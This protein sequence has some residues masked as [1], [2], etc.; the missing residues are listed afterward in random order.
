MAERANPFPGLR[1]FQPGDT[2]V[3]FGREAQTSELLTRLRSNRFVAVVGASGGGKS[4]L[5]LAGL[6]PS[7]H[8]GLM[9]R[10]GSS[11]R[12]A[13]LRPREDP[14]K[15]LAGALSGSDVLGREDEPPE[16]TLAIVETTLRSSSLGLVDTVLQAKLPEHDNVLVVVDQFEEVFRFR[17]ARAAED[18]RL[19]VNLPL[20]AAASARAPIYIVITMRADYIGDCMEFAGLPEAINKGQY[21]VPK[22]TRDG[23]R[24]AV[25][26][27]VAVAGGEI[28]PRLVTR[29]LNEVGD[30][31]NQLPV[32]QHA[33][34]RTWDRWEAGHSSEEPLDIRHYEAIGTMRKAL[35]LHADEVFNGLASDRQRQIA[36]RM[37]RALTDTT[38]DPRG[39]RRPATVAEIG[40]LSGAAPAEVIRVADEFR[41]PGR[42]FLMPPVNVP[43]QPDSILDIS[44]ECLMRIWDRL[45]DWTKQEAQAAQLYRDLAR[46][47]VLRESGGGLWSKAQ[48]LRAVEWRN[49][50]RPNASW[51]QR[52]APG[53]DGAM[54]FLAESDRTERRRRWTLRLALAAALVAPLAGF[55]VY[56]R[57]EAAKLRHEYEQ[58]RA[59]VPPTEVEVAR[60]RS[61]YRSL[62]LEVDSLEERKTRLVTAVAEL[63]RERARLAG[64]IERAQQVHRRLVLERDALNAEL[65]DLR[66]TVT[67]YEQNNTRLRAEVETLD[68]R[69]RALLSRASELGLREVPPTAPIRPPEPEQIVSEVLTSAM[70]SPAVKVDA[71]DDVRDENR[72]LRKETEQLRRQLEALAAEASRLRIQIEA[73]QKQAVTLRNEIAALE[74][75]AAQLRETNHKLNAELQ[76]LAEGN[77]QLRAAVEGMRKQKLDL[78][79][80]LDALRRDDRVLSTRR[81][82][83]E[84]ENRRL[85][86]WIAPR[87]RAP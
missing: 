60:L 10:A 9:A 84:T 59:L 43:L 72:R 11:W 77:K 29:L 14:I 23:L 61:R 17:R 28:S 79:A 82:R 35:S 48:L 65:A 66:K 76:T 54:A 18:A 12:I 40:P 46:S 56:Q 47:A 7:L 74:T 24:A 71:A 13:V 41:A 57:N 26:G 86:A 31:A 1:P 3:F 38:D 87:S 34:M 5:V 2:A 69:N 81:D 62:A 37:F 42:T 50:E 85:E 45:I 44:H 75:S 63:E 25:A 32:L 16:T 39:T 49:A 15:E 68:A 27:P 30:D 36:Q 4:S 70:D 20:E 58:L 22:L 67:K 80:Q 83:L 64:E 6:I 78:L 52:Y 21:L 51:G 33:L 53:F 19:F 73:L 55:A 8:S